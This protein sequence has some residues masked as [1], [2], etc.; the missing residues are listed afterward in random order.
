MKALAKGKAHLAAIQHEIRQPGVIIFGD[1]VD[2]RLGQRFQLVDEHLPHS[3]LRLD[4][5]LAVPQPD[6]D[7]RGEGGVEGCDA[8]GGKEEDALEVFEHAEEDANEGVAADVVGLALLEE[9]VRFV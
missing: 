3:F 2:L 6:V 4:A 1:L 9:D 7:A 5:Q 8:V